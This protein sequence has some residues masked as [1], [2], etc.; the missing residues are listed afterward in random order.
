M[1][2]LKFPEFNQ[3]S[4]PLLLLIVQAYIFAVLLMLRYVKTKEIADLLLAILLIMQGH[5]CFSYIIGFMGWYDTFP[6]TKINYFLFDFTFAIGPLVYFYVRRLTQP[7]FKFQGKHWWHFA[8]ATVIFIYQWLYFGYDVVQS[9]FTQVQN[10]VWKENIDIAYVA[11]FLTIFGYYSQLL[12]YA[13]STQ[14]YWS[15][16]RQIGEIY[17]NTSRVAL[18][19]IAHFL[20][21]W[22][23]LFLFHT[24]MEVLNVAISPLHWTQNWWSYFAS[25]VVILYLGIKGYLTNIPQIT[26]LKK[27]ETATRSADNQA[28]SQPID[29]SPQKTW[30]KHFMQSH[31]PFL[32]P[33]LTLPELAKH[34]EVNTTKL[35]QII[36]QGFQQNFNDFINAYRVEAVK[37]QLQRSSNQHLSLLGIAQ[38]CGFNSKATFN[39]TF[40]KMV[41]QTPSAYIKEIAQSELTAQ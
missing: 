9:G 21:T 24:F 16:R 19:W 25:A 22:A 39:R 37:A 29:W 3:Y 11:P 17:S 31:K 33:D 34:L 14:L 4:T 18:N 15:Y 23:L 36:N 32:N 6:N 30:L 5:H 27:I 38:D 10:G 13:F 35:S 2:L 40:K 28:Q 12:Y 26:R 8:P 41:G 20:A 1:I 7:N